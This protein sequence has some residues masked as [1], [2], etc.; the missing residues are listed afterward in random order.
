MELLDLGGK[1]GDGSLDDGISD[2]VP[3]REV[4]DTAGSDTKFLM[5]L[6]KL[7]EG[8]DVDDAPE[9]DPTVGGCAHR[10]V[11]AGGV[12]GGG[13]ALVGGHVGGGPACEL[14]LGVLRVVSA[15]D[16]VVAFGEDGT[17]CR[18]ED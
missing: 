14:E 6:D 1:F 2:D 4:A 13:L 8:T 11:L 5:P 9:T 3:D 10:A 18:D 15:C 7:L 12:D 16:V 17:V